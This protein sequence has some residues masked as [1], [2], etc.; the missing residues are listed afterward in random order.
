MDNTLIDYSKLNVVILAAGSGKRMNSSLPKVLHT[1]GGI[2]MLERVINTA[3]QLQPRKVCVVYGKGGESVK[4]SMAHLSVEWVDQETPQGTGHAVIQALPHCSDND[5]ILILFGDVPLISSASLLALLENTPKNG[6]GLIV[7][8]LDDPTGF[9]RIIRNEMGNIISIVEH[10][11]ANEEQL[12]I[13]EIN[14]GIMTTTTQHLQ[15][16]LPRLTNDNNKQHEFYLTDIIALAVEDG[17][18]VGGVMAHCKEEVQGVND[19]WQQAKL[20]R[21]Y[22]KHMA[23]Q[24]THQGVQVLDINRLD[25]RGNDIHIA[26]DVTLDVNVVLAG[27][28]RIGTGSVIGPNV[29][30]SNTTVGDYAHIEAFSVLDGVTVGNYATVGPFARLRPDTTIGNHAKVGNFVEL[31]NTQLDEHSKVNHLSYLGDASV[32]SRVNIGAGTITCNYDGV[33]K[34][35]TVIE[36]GAFIGSNTSLIA[37]VTVGKNA[38]IGAGTTL[39]NNAPKDALTLSRSKQDTNVNW[40]SPK[41]KEQTK[42]K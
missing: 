8:E 28:V 29:V 22:Q 15:E 23:E 9:G 34:H 18:P 32:G 31:K 26:K 35:K 17:V 19:R 42:H 38:T 33:N 13:K 7:T 37:P 5:R 21:Y 36:S 1:I 11:D 24:L 6:L 41:Q 39:V 27:D 2:P 30:L 3:N 14:T 10:R 25:I 40:V 16:W 20:E 4:Q 12:H